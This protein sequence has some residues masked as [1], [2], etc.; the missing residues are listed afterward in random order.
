MGC[1]GLP[2]SAKQFKCTI[3]SRG[4]AG[5]LQPWTV[6]CLFMELHCDTMTTTEQR[7][8]SSMRRNYYPQGNTTAYHTLNFFFISFSFFSLSFCSFFSFSSRCFSLFFCSLKS[9]VL[10]LWH[11]LLKTNRTV[12][13]QKGA[14]IISCKDFIHHLKYEEVYAHQKCKKGLQCDHREG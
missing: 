1:C 3:L 14:T 8:Y 7:K 6:Y 2:L 5:K 4:I 9:A 11:S 12:Q 10:G 13:W